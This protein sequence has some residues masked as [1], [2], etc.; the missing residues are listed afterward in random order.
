LKSFADDPA[1]L[2][3][4]RG[5]FGK[6]VPFRVGAGDDASCFN[7]NQVTRPRL[8]ATNVAELSKLGAFSIKSVVDGYRKDWSVLGEGPMMRAFV[9]ESTL[10]WVLKRKLGDRLI[11][12]DERGV[13]F[14]VEI[15]GTLD[16]TVFQGSVV[17]DDARF[18]E[19]FPSAGGARVFLMDSQLEADAGRAELQ[20]ILADRGVVVQT[21]RERLAAFHNVENTYIAVFH[22]LGGLGVLI[23]SAGLGLVTARNMM[24]RRSEFAILH[25]LGIPADVTRRMVVLE[26]AQ[27]IR[28]G[29]GIGL[30]AAVISIL[31]SLPTQGI[32]RTAGWLALWVTLIAA[33]AGFWSWIGYRGPLRHACRGLEEVSS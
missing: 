15:A 11:Y 29:L 7:L 16:A 28:W 33:N 3:D 25:T 8:L 32:W 18:L 14:P 27:C 9:D 30:V 24:E 19:H 4:L 12:Q 20:K 5:R 22:L 10:M 17:V 31:P 23:G 2:G 26:V 1:G 13:D 6:V 21:T